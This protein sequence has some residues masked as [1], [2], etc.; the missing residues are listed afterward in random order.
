MGLLDHEEREDQEEG[1]VAFLA[2]ATFVVQCFSR[3]YPLY[4]R[5]ASMIRSCIAGVR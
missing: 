1:G 3:R 2:L 5:I 4:P